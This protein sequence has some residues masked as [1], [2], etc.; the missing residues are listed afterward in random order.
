MLEAGTC[1]IASSSLVASA[2]SLTAVA[3]G[4]SISFRSPRSDKR[5]VDALLHWIKGARYKQRSNH[6]ALYQYLSQASRRWSEG[7][8]R[9]SRRG[10]R[11]PRGSQEVEMTYCVSVDVIRCLLITRELKGF[12]ERSSRRL[13]GWWRWQQQPPCPAGTDGSSVSKQ[14]FK[15]SQ[16][17]CEHNSLL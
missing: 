8:N 17:N 12:G 6:I 16:K 13:L 2:N 15:Y 3:R 7:H 4:G 14:E 9:R 11:R 10:G 5:R 1:H